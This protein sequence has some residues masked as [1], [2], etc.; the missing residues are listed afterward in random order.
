MS[1]KKFT[2][3]DLFAGCGGLSLGLLNAGWKGF[4]AIEKS[5]DAF[6]TFKWNLIEGNPNRPDKIPQFDMWPEW[7]DIKEWGISGFLDKYSKELK[8]CTGKVNLLVGGPPCQGF[9]IAGRRNGGDPRN[10]L[11]R[12]YIK[13]VRIL[14]P[15]MLMIENVKGM[16]I[17]FLSDGQKGT[18]SYA[19][20]LQVELESLIDDEGNDIG[21]YVTQD[22]ILTEGYGVPQ[23]RPRLL[24]FAFSKKTFSAPPAEPFKALKSM[25]EKFLLSKGLKSNTPVTVAQA[26]SDI[27]QCQNSHDCTDDDSPSG[28]LEITYK[29]NHEAL[30]QYQQLM[31]KGLGNDF[32]PDSLRLVRHR[33]DTV[34]RY[35]LIQETCRKGVQLSPL[36]RESLRNMGVN[37]SK[38]HV[39]VPLSGDQPCHT[40]TTIPDDL[41]HYD[42]PRV[43]TVRENARIQSFPDWFSFKGK[44]TTGGERRKKECPRYTQVGNAVPPL[45]AEAIGLVLIDILS[46]EFD[47]E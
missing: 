30:S 11:F 18:D 37:I 14:Q 4:F 20:I 40:L 34:K 21:Y 5:P 46:D 3:I 29:Q 25:R 32:Q 10:Q 8:D 19:N 42:K 24:T 13:A 28:F 43:H 15:D 6:K 47:R 16:R 17:P 22:V 27:N 12:E 35:K 44:Y 31:R 7:L 36:E 41:L 45:L 38:K 26:L 9:S 23:F 39:V 1:N 33:A 2:F